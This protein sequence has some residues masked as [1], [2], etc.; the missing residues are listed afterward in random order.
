MGLGGSNPCQLSANRQLANAFASGG[1][2]CDRSF[3]GMKKSRYFE[4]QTPYAS[5]GQRE[6]FLSRDEGTAMRRALDSL[7]LASADDSLEHCPPCLIDEVIVD[8]IV[9]R[10]HSVDKRP[11]ECVDKGFQIEIG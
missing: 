3:E 10:E 2:D 9:S 5:C 7:S 4:E 8:W 11:I 6:R 1:K